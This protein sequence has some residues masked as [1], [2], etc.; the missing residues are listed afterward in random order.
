MKYKK[1]KRE[2]NSTTFGPH[3]LCM[4]LCVSVCAMFAWVRACHLAV[5][6]FPLQSI[7]VRLVDRNQI[8]W[9]RLNAQDSLKYRPNVEKVA[10]S[11]C[12]VQR[13]QETWELTGYIKGVR[14]NWSDLQQSWLWSQSELV[15]YKGASVDDRIAPSL[16]NVDWRKGHRPMELGKPIN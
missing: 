13:L 4:W 7:F 6:D 10:W 3:S 1:R 8:C 5:D 2:Q 15:E 11:F 12:K 9:Y 16:Y 14:G